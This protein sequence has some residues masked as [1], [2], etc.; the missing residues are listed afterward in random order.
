MYCFSLA[1]LSS[2]DLLQNKYH[3][4]TFSVLYML[5]IY[6]SKVGVS[7]LICMQAMQSK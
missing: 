2:L 4:A 3:M 6:L 5:D 1:P 7:I